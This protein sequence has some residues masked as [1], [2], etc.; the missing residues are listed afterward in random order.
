M[1]LYRLARRRGEAAPERRLLDQV[2][3]GF[4]EGFET[5]DLADAARLLAE[6]PVC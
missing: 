4:T 3:R 1:S 5:P 2:Y 6:R